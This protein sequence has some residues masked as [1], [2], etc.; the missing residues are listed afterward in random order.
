MIGAAEA[1]RRATLASLTRIVQ[2][3]TC[4]ASRA[5][6]C[7]PVKLLVSGADRPT[8]LNL[9]VKDPSVE[10]ARADKRSSVTA[11]VAALAVYGAAFATLLK[12]CC[13]RWTCLA[14]LR[15]C[16]VEWCWNLAWSVAD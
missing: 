7:G 9:R 13:L 15:S 3:L 8:L 10:T 16:I 2:K 4:R 6:S 11:N 1:I 14:L 12:P 5:D